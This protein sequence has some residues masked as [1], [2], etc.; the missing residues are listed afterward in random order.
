MWIA[1]VFN[2]VYFS[3]YFFECNDAMSSKPNLLFLSGLSR[4][5]A[6]VTI[7]HEVIGIIKLQ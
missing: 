1:L 2:C 4:L 3:V 6:L 5:L 7:K